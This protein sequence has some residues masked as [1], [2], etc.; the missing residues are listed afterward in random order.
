[1]RSQQLQAE[2]SLVRKPVND[3]FALFDGGD[4]LVTCTQE[5]MTLWALSHDWVATHPTLADIITHLVEQNIW[6]SSQRDQFWSVHELLVNEHYVFRVAQSNGAYLEIGLAATSTSGYMVTVRDLSGHGNIEAQLSYEVRRLTFLLGLTERL[7]ASDNLMEIGKFSLTYLLNAMGAAF[8]D[9]KVISGTGSS[10]YAGTLTNLVSGQFIA[11]Y[12]TPAVTDMERALKVGIPYGEGLLWDVVETG[13]PLFV[14]DYA[15]HPKAVKAFRHPGIGQLG[16]F[17]IPSADGA[18]IGVLTLESRTLGKLQEAPQQDMLLAAC[19]ILGAAIDRVQSHERL[20][21][22]NQNLEEA[23]RLKSEFLAAMSH[24][25]RTPLNS[26]LGFSQLM[27]RRQDQLGD[28]DIRHLNAIRQG[29]HHLLE[30]INDILDLSKVEAGKVE[31]ELASVDVQELCRQCMSMVQPR[32]ER[33]RLALSLEVDYRIDRVL[34][35]ERR[36]RQMIVNLLSNAAKFTPEK[37]QVKLSLKLAYGNQL[38]VEERPDESPVNPSTPYLCIEVIDTGIGIPEHKKH[39]LFCPFQQ[40]DSSLTRQ[41]DGSGLGLALTKR[42][43]ELHGGTISYTSTEGQG[44]TFRIWLPINELREALRQQPVDSESVA[45]HIPRFGQRDIRDASG[46]VRILVVEDQPY[47]QTLI[48]EVL[49]TEGYQV[50]LISHGRTMQ[51]IIMSDRVQPHTLPDLILMDIQLPGVD[52]FTL[53]KAIKAHST[54]QKVP[55]IAVTAL[56]M[57]GDRQRCL[58]AGADAYLSKPLDFQSLIVEVKRL[59]TSVPSGP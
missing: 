56:A 53:V 20:Q 15:A 6:T 47:N 24:E 25:L 21:Q 43:A 23:S 2:P 11:T 46:Q 42:L 49:E 8:G 26:I 17:P 35:D 7:Q 48:S 57:S 39:L 5:L 52:G 10:R 19:R 3:A 16:I 9:V 33:K 14:E 28:R 59:L 41:H 12:G 45:D 50:E 51:S 13:K 30:L 4:R 38:L 58:D 18:I 22:I 31:L 44:S 37:G 54:W 29:G 36:T 32:A 34:L 1:M 55:V 40:I 27:L